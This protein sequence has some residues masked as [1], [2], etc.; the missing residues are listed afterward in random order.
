MSDKA[1]RWIAWAILEP[2]GK[3]H[4]IS[5]ECP[6]NSETIKRLIYMGWAAIRVDIIERMSPPA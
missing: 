1:R 6:E 4:R 5:M 3:L 2:D